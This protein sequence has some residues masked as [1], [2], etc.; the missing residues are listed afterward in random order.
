[1]EERFAG[2]PQAR[3]HS[4]ALRSS[5]AA[6]AGM[7]SFCRMRAA[8]PGAVDNGGRGGQGAASVAG[9]PEIATT[10]RRASS[11]EL[12]AVSK[13]HDDV[14]VGEDSWRQTIISYTSP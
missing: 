14:T 3:R 7:R 12:R 9:L 10:Q 8:S 5:R 13:N 4:S 1:M 6:G 11:G 2:G